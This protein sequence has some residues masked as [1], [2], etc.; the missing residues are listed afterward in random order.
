M[1][2]PQR[3]ADRIERFTIDVFDLSADPA[4]RMMVVRPGTRDVGRLAVRRRP[5]ADRAL[6]QQMLERPVDRRESDLG[7]LT[8]EPREDIARREIPSFVAQYPRDQLPWPRNI[9]RTHAALICKS[10]ANPYPVSP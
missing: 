5:G 4:D 6:G 8:L 1:R 9:I 10:L 7:P 2:R 3:I